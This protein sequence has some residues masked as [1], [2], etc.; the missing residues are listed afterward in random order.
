MKV[1]FNYNQFTEHSSYISQVDEWNI[2]FN[3]KDTTL[4][5]FL[6]NHLDKRINLIITDIKLLNFCEEISKKYSNVY[7][8]FKDIELKELKDVDIKFKFFTNIGK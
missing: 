3:E 1:C 5:E 8:N 2:V 7:I 4:L 6:D